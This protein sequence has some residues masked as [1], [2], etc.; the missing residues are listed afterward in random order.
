MEEL[1]LNNRLQELIEQK[2]KRDKV[3]YTN[4][5]IADAIGVTVNT[6]RSYANN[7]VRMY[8]RRTLNKF[9]RW[10]EVSP[11]EFFAVDD[12]EGNRLPQQRTLAYN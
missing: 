8:D 9:L 2:K 7:Y 6:L 12:Q 3:E 5:Q 4:E 11:G 1:P 10:L